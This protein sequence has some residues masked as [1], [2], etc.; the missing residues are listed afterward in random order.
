MDG[1]ED[2][3]EAAD[4]LM[5][6][7]GV[8]PSDVTRKIE[9]ALG[10]RM[11]EP[12]RLRTPKPGKPVARVVH[13]WIADQVEE[14]AQR[15]AQA[16]LGDPE[17]V[18][19]ARVACRR[20]RS[21]LATFRPYLDR[22]V[23]DPLREELRWLARALGEVRD[24]GVAHDRLTR[25]L[26][27][28]PRELVA[29]PVARRLRDTYGGAA[30]LPGALDDPRYLRLRGALDLLVTDPPWTPKADRPARKAVRTRLRKEVERVGDRFPADDDE[31]LHRLRKASKRLRYAAEAARPVCGKR[32][33]RLA[34]AARALTDHLGKRQDTVTSRDLLVELARAARDAGEPT[35]TYGR[36]HARE[37]ATAARLDDDLPA[38]W[39]RF[40]GLARRST[41]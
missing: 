40:T 32:S 16:R 21:A 19:K 5:A 30:R 11:P 23:T 24:A 7:H 39:R 31:A 36:L 6:D 33:K 12:A 41:C 17:G 20:L 3:L 35:F 29:G 18:H 2:L 25:L 26:R 15:E 14:L 22:E 37:E 1:D 38:E 27:S 4:A 28:E 10:D 9:R 13:A 8:A 34:K